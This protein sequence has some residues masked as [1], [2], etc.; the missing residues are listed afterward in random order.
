MQSSSDNA[1]VSWS[2]WGSGEM[3]QGLHHFIMVTG[4]TK[5]RLQVISCINQN[6]IFKNYILR[7]GLSK[8][9]YV[10]KKGFDCL[11]R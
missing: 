2:P 11:K 10:E 6:L 1:T 4:R 5:D 7:I 8:K 3:Q 9:T